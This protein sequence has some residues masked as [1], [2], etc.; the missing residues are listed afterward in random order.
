MRADIRSLLDRSMSLSMVVVRFARGTRWRHRGVASLAPAGTT[1]F[2]PYVLVYDGCLE[3]VFIRMNDSRIYGQYGVF[4][5][6]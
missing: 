2:N 1:D 6:D 5:G 4:F 3:D